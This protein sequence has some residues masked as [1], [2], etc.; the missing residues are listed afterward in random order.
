[1]GQDPFSASPRFVF[2]IPELMDGIGLVPIVMGLFGISEV[3]LNIEQGL[4]KRDIFGVKIK[5]LLPSLQDWKNSI[6]PILRGSIA[7]F[8]IGVIPGGGVIIASFTSYAMEKKFSKHPERF[9]TG[10]IEGVAGPE[11][12][13]NAAT[14]GAL[15]P[16]LTLGIPSNVM[17]ALL[18]GALMIHGVAP[19]PLLIQKKPEIFWGIVAS[20]YLGNAMLLALNLPLI[21]L[22]V[23]V[24][25]VPYKILFP[26]ILFFCLIGAYSV[27]N[28]TF[29]IG[30]ML[31]FGVL[32]YFMRKYD[33][34]AGPFVLA[35]VL[36]PILETSLRQS[37]LMS[38]GSFSIFFTR[39]I[40]GGAIILSLF[41]LISSIFPAIRKRKRL[42]VLEERIL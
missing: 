5:N 28:S 31:L 18:L 8:F 30:V 42:M 36:G 23:Q 9:G 41:M 39:P 1:M 17:M 38:K 25:K 35:Y 29:D 40:A 3:F 22:W 16:L 26:L 24:L 10:M 13:N 4:E 11:T 7:G 12:A 14:G 15:V 33:Y 19:G 20:L 2:G 34:E 32:G 6:G 21:G 37:L 27:S